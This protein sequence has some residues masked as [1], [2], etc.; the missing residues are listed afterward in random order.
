MVEG[1]PYGGVYDGLVCAGHG[2][3]RYAEMLGKPWQRRLFN[4]GRPKISESDELSN[5]G[6][7]KLALKAY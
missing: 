4:D 6:K 1:G 2:T 3:C 7:A 5:R